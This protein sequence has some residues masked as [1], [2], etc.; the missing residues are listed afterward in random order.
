MGM[1]GDGDGYG[2]GD[3][4]RDGDGDGDGDGV[5]RAVPTDERSRLLL[6]VPRP[7]IQRGHKPEAGV[8]RRRNGTHRQCGT[9]AG[10]TLSHSQCHTRR[11]VS[12][13][14]DPSAADTRK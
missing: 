2:Y 14:R 4:Y 7:A 13:S 5:W 12:E 8:C 1:A 6:S 10:T 3:G 11:S 9:G